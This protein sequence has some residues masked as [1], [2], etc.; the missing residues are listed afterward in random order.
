MKV[1]T[2][3]IMLRIS[4][5]KMPTT[6]NCNCSLT[7]FI[8]VLYF[9]CDSRLNDL[10]KMAIP[11]SLQPVNMLLYIANGVLCLQ[12]GTSSWLAQSDHEYLKAENLSRLNQG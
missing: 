6:I 1:K 7:C 12:T 10:Q 8:L 2:Q 5:A 9:C 4:G 3:S 11:Q